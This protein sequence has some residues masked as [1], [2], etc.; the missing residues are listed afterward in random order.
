MSGPR[1]SAHGASKAT[2]RGGISGW[3]SRLGWWWQAPLGLL[4]VS[5]V[6]VLITTI[7]FGATRP[8]TGNPPP[9]GGSASA[10]PI[11]RFTPMASPTQERPAPELAELDARLAAIEA[12]YDVLI[13]LS[14]TQ[15]GRPFTARQLSW[16]G[17][18][19]RGGAAL[20]T[21]DVPMALAVLAE[22]RQPLQR[23]YIL[24]KA[25]ADD[26]AAGDEAIWAF[27]GEPAEAAAKTTDALRNYGDWRSLVPAESAHHPAAPYLDTQ[28]SLESQSR[29]AGA[30]F[31]DYVDTH[32]VISKLND[33]TDD[34]WGL[35]TLPMTYAKGAWGKM[36]NGDILVRQFGII[37]LA[38]GTE[39]GIALA[40]SG[41]GDEPLLGQAAITELSN[42]VRLLASGIDPPNC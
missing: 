10:R 30:V 25:L 4:I 38:D 40:T 23:D 6:I 33:P 41:P 7:A 17:G 14:L 29:F 39:V 13:G 1:R 42:A 5:I 34:P 12:K 31:C 35:Q 22:P 21:I 37:R 36:P 9:P 15:V 2:R 27:L 19:L 20:A 16:A 3:R 28:W 8:N 26:S 24:T 11:P 18:T 32:P